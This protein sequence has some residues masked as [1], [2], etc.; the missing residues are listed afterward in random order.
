MEAA[1]RA[2]LTV[3]SISDVG[4]RRLANEDAYVNDD[5]FGLY[6]VCD[7]IGGQPS[8]EAASQTVVHALPHVLRR[9]LREAGHADDASVRKALT[10]ALIEISAAMQSVA[11]DIDILRGMG[12]TAVGLLIDR[13]RGFL[14]HAGDS[15][16]YRL[17]DGHL[18]RLTHDHVR[19]YNRLP[20]PGRGKPGS[21]RPTQRRL[22]YQFMGMGSQLDPAITDLRLEPGDRHLL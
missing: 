20:A 8:G 13:S 9:R 12:A 18:D 1:D 14:F 21:A 10:L 15:R 16:A 3:R 11:Q 6:V 2:H 5:R 19:S 7:G 22:L 17:R 4:L